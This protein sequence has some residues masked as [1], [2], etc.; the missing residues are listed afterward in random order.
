MYLLETFYN[1][2]TITTFAKVWIGGFRYV[3]FE[4]IVAIGFKGN[5]NVV[6]KVSLSKRMNQ[7][8]LKWIETNSTEFA[9]SIKKE[10]Y[11]GPCIS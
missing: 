10:F 9:R 11:K 6:K 8:G 7:T 3:I 1:V 4:M 2:Y 5:C